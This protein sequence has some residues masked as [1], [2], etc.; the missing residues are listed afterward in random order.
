MIKTHLKDK[1]PCDEWVEYLETE[2]ENEYYEEMFEGEIEE[3]V[4]EEIKE[5]CINE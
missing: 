2:K 4:L 5:D 3:D 1:F